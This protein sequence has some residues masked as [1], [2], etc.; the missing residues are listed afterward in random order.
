[1]VSTTAVMETSF[2]ENFREFIA[3]E[4]DPAIRSLR[5]NA[6]AEFTAAG[7]PTPKHEDWKYTNVA[8]LVSGQWSVAGGQVGDVAEADL[9]LLRRFGSDRN[10]FAAL[11]LAF[12]DI[13]VIRIAKEMSIA[14]PSNCHSQLMRIPRSFRTFW[15]SPRLA[16]RQRSWNLM[17]RR[18][19]VLRTP[20]SRSWSR[21]T[22]A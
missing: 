4:T 22:R 1:M 3:K 15:S 21:T 16:A 20:R 11:N 8:P 5:E 7:F 13:K 14:E 2:S 17:I 10:G 9:E 6:F 19:R 12:A 18:R